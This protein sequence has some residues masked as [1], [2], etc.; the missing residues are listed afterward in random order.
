MVP[1]HHYTKVIQKIL[2]GVHAARWIRGFMPAAILGGDSADV[3]LLR[4]I[5]GSRYCRPHQ[6]GAGSVGPE[7]P[8]ITGRVQRRDKRI[9]YDEDLLPQLDGTKQYSSA[10]IVT[11]AM[12][13]PA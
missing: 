7:G 2:A 9:L 12:K 5:P 11:G 13:V 10:E 3:A 6:A 8:A 4:R 1:V